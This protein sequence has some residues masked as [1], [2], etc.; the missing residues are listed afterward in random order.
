MRQLVSGAVK[1]VAAHPDRREG[2]TLRCDIAG[3]EPLIVEG[4]DDLLHRAVFNLLLNAV[5]ATPPGGQV[6][7]VVGDPTPAEQVPGGMRAARD[8]IAIRVSDRA[9][10]SLPRSASGC[11]TRSSPPSPG[12]AASGSPSCTAPSRRTAASCSSTGG[13]GKRFTIRCRHSAGVLP[14]TADQTHHH[15]ALVTKTDAK[16][17]SA[18]RRRRGGHPRLAAHPA[19]QRGLQ[20]LHG[21]GRQ[22]GDRVHRRAFARHRA[23]RRPHADGHR[24]RGAECGAP[25]RPGDRR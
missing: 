22:A 17:Q 19:A 18:R 13:R 24:H 8:A 15:R 9:P 2:A 6:C 14:R 3:D 20:L 5:Q 7:V 16:D 23:H 4:D 1:L 10:A 25:A 21:T 12:A 11:S